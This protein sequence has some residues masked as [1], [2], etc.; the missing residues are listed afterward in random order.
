MIIDLLSIS[1]KG[2]VS[3]LSH[4][5]SFDLEV[6]R[7]LEISL[8]LYIGCLRQIELLRVE[9]IW[10]VYDLVNDTATATWT[11]T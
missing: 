5:R 1:V 8:A 7:Y 6:A 9:G 3:S 11:G 4:V 2:G 10:F